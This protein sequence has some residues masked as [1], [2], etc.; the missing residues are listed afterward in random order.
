MANFNHTKSHE[1][2]ISVISWRKITSSSKTQRRVAVFIP[3]GRAL[4]SVEVGSLVGET[5]RP[6]LQ[7][8]R[9]REARNEEADSKTEEIC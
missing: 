9:V 8:G 1:I 4:S 6:L 7:G 2:K 5:Y 3:D